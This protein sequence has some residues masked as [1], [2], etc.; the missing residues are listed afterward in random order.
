MAEIQQATI[1]LLCPSL[2][3]L[4]LLIDWAHERRRHWKAETIVGG[5]SFDVESIYQTDHDAL[6]GII[7]NA[8]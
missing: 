7:A 5:W 1:G 3:T 8:S 4:L 6:S 2:E